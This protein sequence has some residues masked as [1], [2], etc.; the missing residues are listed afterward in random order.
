LVVEVEEGGQAGEVLTRLVGLLE[1]GVVQ[2]HPVALGQREHEL[3]LKRA[4]WVHRQH[5][6][7]LAGGGQDASVRRARVDW[8]L[9]VE[10]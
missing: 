2:L 1:G 4:L 7:E 6:D 10:V 8:N 3:W 9:D 5:T